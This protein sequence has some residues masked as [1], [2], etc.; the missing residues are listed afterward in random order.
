M[1]EHEHQ[2][3]E[4][5]LRAPTADRWSMRP[6]IRTKLKEHVRNDSP[7]KHAELSKAAL[8]TDA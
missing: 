1:V 5:S 7:A 8:G 4:A 2:V 3:L 6:M